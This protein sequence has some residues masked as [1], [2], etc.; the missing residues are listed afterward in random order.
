MIGFG[1]ESVLALRGDDYLF[2]EFRDF[3]V[4]FGFLNPTL[5]GLDSGVGF[6]LLEKQG[7]ELD[8]SGIRRYRSMSI[9]SPGEGES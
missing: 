5:L 8:D 6:S 4:L 2:R 3:F 7:L 9:E 1:I